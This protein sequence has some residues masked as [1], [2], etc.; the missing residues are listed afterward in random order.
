MI[1]FSEFLLVIIIAFIFNSPD[2]M[3]SYIRKFKKIKNEF[4]SLKSK[5]FN[6]LNSPKKNYTK[7]I[8]GDDGKYYPTYDKNDES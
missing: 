7:I 3:R 1:G 8:K 5:T 2:E 6:E 4:D